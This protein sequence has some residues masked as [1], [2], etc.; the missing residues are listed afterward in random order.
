MRTS[1]T[2]NGLCRRCLLTVIMFVGKHE[3]CAKQKHAYSVSLHTT[4]TVRTRYATLVWACAHH[5]F[6]R[7]E[8]LS[9]SPPPVALNTWHLPPPPLTFVTIAAVSNFCLGAID[10]IHSLRDHYALEF[11]ILCIS[12]AHGDR[13]FTSS[14]KVITRSVNMSCGDHS[15]RYL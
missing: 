1:C 9:P 15:R 10:T 4:N 14:P 7:T 8:H 11:T 2:V 3:I 12:R 6:A 5:L 13:S